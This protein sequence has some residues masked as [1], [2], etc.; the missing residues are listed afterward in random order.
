MLKNILIIIFI[1]C[2]ALLVSK[3]NVILTR[4]SCDSS[5][6]KN[7][8][9][10][11]TF[12]G[13]LF[14]DYDLRRHFFPTIKKVYPKISQNDCIYD[15]G[16]NIGDVAAM[17]HKFYKT[18]KIFLAEPLELNCESTKIRFNLSKLILTVNTAIGLNRKTIIWNYNKVGNM[19]YMKRNLRMSN[20]T[21]LKLDNFYEIY[22]KIGNIFFLKIDVEGYEDEVIFSSKNLLKSEKIKIIYFEYHNKCKTKCSKL[23]K[24]L[25]EFGFNCYLIGKYKI[26]RINVQCYSEINTHILSH[27]VC[28]KN[29]LGKEN[30]FIDEYNKLY[31]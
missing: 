28:I 24:Y 18:N 5:Y 3:I 25:N 1:I 22:T 11:D 14:S 29:T 30:Q 13:T 26:I 10:F 2:I 20:I 31:T 6:V 27:V 15:I 17:F 8:K 7:K 19:M 12:N 9:Y 4:K 23:V 16:S 21:F